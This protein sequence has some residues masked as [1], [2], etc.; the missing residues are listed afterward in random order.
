MTDDIF[1]EVENVL[2]YS[3]CE[4]TFQNWNIIQD[5]NYTMQEENNNIYL[6]VDQAYPAFAHWIYESGV[7]LSY[8]HELK[9]K[10]P[11]IKLHFKDP[12][13]Y[14]F[15]FCKILGILD[16]DIVTSVKVPNRFLFPKPISSLNKHNVDN[17]HRRLIYNLFTFFNNEYKESNIIYDEVVMPRQSKENFIGNNC[18]HPLS[19]IIAKFKEEKR[20]FIIL[21]TDF[22]LNFKDQINILS[23]CKNIICVDG[24]ALLVNSMFVKGKI[25]HIP[26]GLCTKEQSVS[27][28]QL[29]YILECAR[30]INNNEIRY[31]SSE[32]DFILNYN[33]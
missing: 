24:S 14:K 5:N 30:I 27:H 18:D 32:E 7:F 3:F 19:L 15:L 16:T 6:V 21:N 33:Q 22:I 23:V 4:K 26:A 25:F 12:R 28:P 9:K 31:Y 10:Y 8:F 20:N 29:R 2:S 1:S 13:N 17:E 11:T